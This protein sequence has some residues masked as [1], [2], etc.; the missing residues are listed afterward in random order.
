MARAIARSRATAG[1]TTTAL[2][3]PDAG[4][5]LVD[6]GWSP[7]TT[8]G[9]RWAGFGG[10]PAGNARAR[11]ALWRETLAFLARTLGP[12]AGSGGAPK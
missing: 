10:T 2:I 1:L 4:H 11:A 8:V 5:M 9:G 12:P 7:A 6:D 3:Y